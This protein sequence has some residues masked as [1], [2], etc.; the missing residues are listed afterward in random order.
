MSQMQGDG[1]EKQLD[2]PS[3]R[4]G[5]HNK[6]EA[7]LKWEQNDALLVYMVRGTLLIILFTF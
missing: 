7:R 4:D 2:Q 3:L 1:N 5:V 6:E